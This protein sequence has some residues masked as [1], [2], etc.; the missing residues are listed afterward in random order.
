MHFQ[1]PEAEIHLYHEETC[2]VKPSTLEVD[3][4]NPELHP[5]KGLFTTKARKKDDYITC[6]PGYWMH[7]QVYE[8]RDK[9]DECYAFSMPP[10]MVGWEPMRDLVY[11]THQTQANFIN[12]GIVKIKVI[13][14]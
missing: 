6:F 3:A 8:A 1:I 10:D 13:F 5:G 7:R 4:G 14:V 11:V 9:A 12:A 2:K